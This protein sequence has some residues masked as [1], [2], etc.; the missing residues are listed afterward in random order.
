VR[1]LLAVLL[2]GTRPL[3][4]TIYQQEGSKRFILL[5]PNHEIIESLDMVLQVG[6][7]TDYFYDYL[8]DIGSREDE[9]SL[10]L[11]SLYSDL[12]QFDK[13]VAKG[14]D[15]NRLIEKAL[16]IKEDYLD[17]ESEYHVTVRPEV[18][19]PTLEKLEDLQRLQTEE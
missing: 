8:K 2:S 3:F 5:P 7:A 15:S 16:I 14:Y 6:I 17:P 18:L 10:Y 12:K 19:N 11:F 4:Q 1:S 13:A 9:E